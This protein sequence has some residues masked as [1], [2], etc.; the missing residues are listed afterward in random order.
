ML[1]KNF[2]E[3]TRNYISCGIL[4]TVSAGLLFIGGYAKIW[5]YRQPKH[6]IK[7]AIVRSVE[8]YYY[9]NDLGWSSSGYKI[10]IEGDTRLIDFPSEKLNKTFKVGD[11]VDLIVRRSFPLF[12]KSDILDGIQINN[13]E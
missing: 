6:E 2:R 12:G 5:E 3:N 13:K 8:P 9:R 11:S 1:I 4:T 7:N 10:F